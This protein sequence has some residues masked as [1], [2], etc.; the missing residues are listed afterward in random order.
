MSTQTT[1]H[2]GHRPGA[3]RK[4][5]GRNRLVLSVTEDERKQIKELL[6][7]MRTAG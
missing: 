1:T 5:T 4:P 2:G 3:G 7:K 6:D